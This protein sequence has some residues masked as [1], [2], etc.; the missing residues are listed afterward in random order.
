MSSS[1]GILADMSTDT[2]NMPSEQRD[3]SWLM[4]RLN[5][6]WLSYF[7]D[8]TRTNTVQAVFGQ[9]SKTRLGSIGM[10]GWRK[11]G[12][13]Q[14]YKMARHINEDTTVIKLTGYF[15]N[16]EIP[17]YVIDVTIAH[18]IIH[19]AHGFHSPLPQLYPHPHQGGI[20]DKELKRR[21]LGDMLKLQ[22]AWLKTHWATY[23]PV[24]KPRRR[25]VKRLSLLQ[26]ISGR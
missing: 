22:K 14:V 19:Y 8:I 13:D 15:K 16:P 18:E 10:Q 25:H 21:G 5:T 6:I 24:R 11:T 26:L 12:K 7:P 3:E 9:Q 1:S 4:D 17:G 20:V 23:I 2:L